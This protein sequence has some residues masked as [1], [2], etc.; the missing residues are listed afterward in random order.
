M[1]HEQA[2]E[3]AHL[4][5]ANVL[6]V[7]KDGLEGLWQLT[8]DED[9]GQHSTNSEP[10][11]AAG[12]RKANYDLR[13]AF[14]S[15]PRTRAGTGGIR[16]P[17]DL[18]VSPA[19][20]LRRAVPDI[21]LSIGTFNT[22]KTIDWDQLTELAATEK[23]PA[24]SEAEEGE[25]QSWEHP[26]TPTP[27]R[28]KATG[29][30]GTASLAHRSPTKAARTTATGTWTHTASN[31]TGAAG[32][33]YGATTSAAPATRSG[34]AS[35]AA[36]TRATRPRMA[37]D[38]ASPAPTEEPLRGSSPQYTCNQ[39]LPLPSLPHQEVI[40]LTASPLR[41]SASCCLSVTTAA[42][43]QLGNSQADS[44]SASTAAQGQHKHGAARNKQAGGAQNL[45]IER[46][47]AAKLRNWVFT[48]QTRGAVSAPTWEPSAS[49]VE[50]F[51]SMVGGHSPI[52]YLIV[53]L[54]RTQ[55]GRLHWQGYLE[56]NKPLTRWQIME[57]N[58]LMALAWFGGRR[59]TQEQAIDYIKGEGRH[60]GKHGE[61]DQAVPGGLAK[62]LPWCGP[63]EFGKRHNGKGNKQTDLHEAADRIRAGA[64]IRDIAHEMPVTFVRHHRGLT[65]LVQHEQAP[66]DH[67]TRVLWFWGDAGTGKTRL[68]HMF[69]SADQRFVWT[70]LQAQWFDGYAGQ[71]V[72]IF[73]DVEVG[74]MTRG[75]FN[76]MMDR[77]AQ[78]VQVKGGMQQWKPQLVIITSNYEPR[79]CFSMMEDKYWEAVDR[80]LTL[81]RY[82]SSDDAKPAHEAI[83][84]LRTLKEDIVEELE[85]AGIKIPKEEDVDF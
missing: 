22:D 46:P 6:F 66:R 17:L 32:R 1:S 51:A 8:D 57:M 61:G 62:D 19:P 56:A 81:V 10:P 13:D 14:A 9:E 73:D 65:A 58:D 55:G 33:R 48:I 43:R 3:Y 78:L 85:A 44:P 5:N 53:G 35:N 12:K 60:E 42:A 63:H 24:A 34:T 38:P 74:W 31:G 26:P 75:A 59:G 79:G 69:G 80:R 7:D 68:A 21:S 82:F 77:Y 45:A 11:R 27:P 18:T 40:D 36:A 4:H 2:R 72:A 67:T 16:S 84:V 15:P 25:L 54:E 83:A 20:I 71:P 49:N 37:A 28:T 30:T 23:S 76:T 47:D 29:R 39:W 50:V 41:P 52:D 70:S 64:T